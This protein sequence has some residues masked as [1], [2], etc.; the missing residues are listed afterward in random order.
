MSGCSWGHTPVRWC[1]PT[2]PSYLRPANAWRS[3][4]WSWCGSG[5]ARSWSTT[6]TT[7]TSPSRP[8]LV[9]S[10]KTFLRRIE[11]GGDAS[12]EGHAGDVLGSHTEDRLTVERA[13]LEQHPARCSHLRRKS[14]TIWKSSLV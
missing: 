12:D 9:S 11:G 7:T 5:T 13:R 14:W 6:C 2:A 4:A 8:S 1:C 3:R 10:R